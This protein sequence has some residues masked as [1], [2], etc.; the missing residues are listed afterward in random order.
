MCVHVQMMENE[1]INC[2][3]ISLRVSGILGI[4][5]CSEHCDDI[6]YAYGTL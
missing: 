1:K 4:N 2:G 6:T 3:K 5:G